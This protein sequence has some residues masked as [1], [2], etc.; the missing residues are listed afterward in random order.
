MRIVVT[1][2]DGIDSVGLHHLAAA[3][4]QFGEVIIVAPDSEYSGAGAALGPLHLIR[5][6][7]HRIV[8][9][10]N[11]VAS[12]WT[13]AGPPALWVMFARLGV[14]G[15]TPDL[16]VSGINP[17]ANVGRAVY[18]SGTIGA[19]LTARGGLISGIA[20]SQDVSEGAID[21]Q[22]WDNMLLQQKWESAAVVA[23]EVVRA[24]IAAPPDEP[25]VLNINV[26]NLELDEIRG[27]RYTSVAAIPPR[28]VV[29]ASLEAKTGHTDAF[30]VVMSFGESVVLPDETD[31]GAVAAGYIS[32]CALSKLSAEPV[33][34]AMGLGLSAAF[35]TR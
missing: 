24:H 29:E 5:P 32:V 4:V 30:R 3:M 2:D 7:V 33:S 11:G 35:P 15:A 6:D 17:G 8:S 16:V 19:A 20:I 27:W 34:E 28:T 10:V 26:P 22:G 23:T 18:H 25:V 31:G 21:G 9:P 13:V 1:N 14:F 12:A